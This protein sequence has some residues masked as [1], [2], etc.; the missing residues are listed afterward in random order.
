LEEE[1]KPPFTGTTM[2]KYKR[3]MDW[4]RNKV[5]E[6]FSRGYSQFEISNMLHISQS[7]IS[8]DINYMQSKINKRD[9]DPD[10]QLFDEYEKIMLTLDETVKEL[11]KI[12]DSSKTGSKEKAKSINL[13]LH[14]TKERRLILE[15]KIDIIK[16][17]A[18][19][20]LVGDRLL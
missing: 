11:W 1:T 8:R 7:T 20:N 15:K 3:Q 16:T 17:K 14:I 13:I 18:Y 4:R 5:R 19:R 6:L 2:K 12:I 9:V 10:D